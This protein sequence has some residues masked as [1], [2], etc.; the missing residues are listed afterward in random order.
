MAKAHFQ[1]IY[2]NIYIDLCESKMMLL[3]TSPPLFYTDGSRKKREFLDL[4]FQPMYFAFDLNLK[5]EF[6]VSFLPFYSAF[7]SFNIQFVSFSTVYSKFDLNESSLSFESLCY[8]SKY[9]CYLYPGFKVNQILDKTEDFEKLMSN[10]PVP[11]TKF[12]PKLFSGNKYLQSF[13]FHKRVHRYIFTPSR[14]IIEPYL[15]VHNNRAIN[16][17]EAD[18]VENFCLF[19]FLDEN[20][21]KVKPSEKKLVERLNQILQTGFFGP[22]KRKFRFLGATSSQVLEHSAWFTTYNPEEFLSSM[23][24][25]E[26]ILNPGLR[27]SRIG[28]LFSSTMSIC[29]IPSG[30]LFSASEDI[31][32]LDFKFKF[33]D[34]CGSI[35]LAVAQI[36]QDKLDLDFLPSAVQFRV[37]PYKG[38]LSVN[39]RQVEPFKFRPSMK[40]FFSFNRAFE[41]VGFSKPNKCYLNRQLIMILTS[42]GLEEKLFLD[43]LDNDI[44]DIFMSNINSIQQ[45]LSPDIPFF[46]KDCLD[47]LV[48]FNVENDNFWTNIIHLTRISMI[49]NLKDKARIHVPQGRLLL[50][51]IDEFNI[52]KENEVYI[53]ITL[54]D[55]S[56]KVIE[57]DLILI[58]NPCIHPGDLR[59]ATAI[60][61]HPDYHGLVDVII[62]P[63]K[64]VR[65]LASQTSGGDLDGDQ[66]TV[67]WDPKLRP[68][69]FFEPMTEGPT[70]TSK[71]KGSIIDAYIKI[72]TEDCIG[73]LSHAQLALADQR[74]G[75]FLNQDVIDFSGLISKAV[76]F[77][78]R[79]TS[80]D[81]PTAI[82][83]DLKYP[84]YLEKHSSIS[85]ISTHA[86]GFIYRKCKSYL[87][88]TKPKITP[89]I[90]SHDYQS[91]FE[92]AYN[93][94]SNKLFSIGR[95]YQ[96]ENEY[97]ILTGCVIL[98]AFRNKESRIRA[99]VNQMVSVLTKET[100]VRIMQIM[101]NELDSSSTNERGLLLKKLT[102]AL[103]C[104]QLQS[105]GWCVYEIL[106]EHDATKIVTGSSINTDRGL[107]VELKK[108]FDVAKKDILSEYQNRIHLMNRVDLV[109]RSIHPEYKAFLYGS[110]SYLL[111]DYFSDTDIGIYSNEPILEAMYVLLKAEFQSIQYIKNARV[112]IL[113]ST[114][115]SFDI[116][117][118]IKGICKTLIILH[119]ID[120]NP[121]F[122]AHFLL[123]AQFGRSFGLIQSQRL[124]ELS[125]IISTFGL[126]YLYIQHIRQ[127]NE[128]HIMSDATVM[129]N[130]ESDI[131]TYIEKL[132]K[133]LDNIIEK[134]ENLKFESS[135]VL[136]SF[137]QKYSKA[138]AIKVDDPVNFG[139]SLVNI[140]DEKIIYFNSACLEFLD[141]LHIYKNNI[142]KL[143]EKKDIKSIIRLPNH[144]KHEFETKL[145]F[146]KE[147][148]IQQAS[149]LAKRKILVDLTIDVKTYNSFVHLSGP[150]EDIGIVQPILNS[151][152]QDIVHYK[153]GSGG[154]TYLLGSFHLMVEDSSHDFTVV[155]FE[156]L[157]RNKSI[158]DE[159]YFIKS[160]Q[161]RLDNNLMK[162]RI[163]CKDQL[164]H[165]DC[166]ESLSRFKAT[167]KFGNLYFK[168]I[169]NAAMEIHELEDLL[170]HSLNQTSMDK[171]DDKK[172]EDDQNQNFRSL[173]ILDFDNSSNAVKEQRKKFH[174]KK[175]RSFGNKKAK[176]SIA[177]SR[178]IVISETLCNFLVSQFQLEHYSTIQELVI[179]S[180]IDGQLCKIV[181][182]VSYAP[183]FSKILKHSKRLLDA[184]LVTNDSLLKVPDIRYNIESKDFIKDIKEEY[185][186]ILNINQAIKSI[187]NI[188]FI[189]RDEVNAT[190][191][192]KLDSEVLK[193]FNASHIRYI[194][195]KGFSCSMN[196]DG[197]FNLISLEYFKRFYIN[198]VCNAEVRNGEAKVISDSV[199]IQ[200]DV[201]M[202]KSTKKDSEMERFAES[203]YNL[204]TDVI[205]VMRENVL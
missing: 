137:F 108:Y 70:I 82:V 164:L 74:P 198:K 168:N 88:L 195:R 145:S 109:C 15:L 107:N 36:V 143:F 27:L 98:K 40:K 120:T 112:P 34:G 159:L 141:L 132:P 113:K 43:Y 189:E 25:F 48:T 149:K 205:K 131:L 93:E 79:L 14:M 51:I 11:F 104:F 173:K 202:P 31:F 196:P 156:K 84:D 95:L 129:K 171:I 61:K 138:K 181:I 44:K 67:I 92:D 179:S 134:L 80:F 194:V 124:N 17:E 30:S 65:D 57:G 71:F 200:I 68:P 155:Q 191:P 12:E 174:M 117:Q 97:E 157:E 24:N 28:L 23:G 114:T 148:I 18:V 20:F 203:F 72:V 63:S 49:K 91:V 165:L 89:Q 58:K 162:F 176:P 7:G 125:Q 169:E 83:D 161:E 59:P 160:Q 142:S 130:Y 151:L 90:M 99:H 136:I 55:Q 150:S 126:I 153:R 87:N 158:R 183:K 39:N 78:K 69:E 3:F 38:V 21:N 86:L 106:F 172:V 96:C 119:V 180:K 133:N 111:F 9:S 32:T 81:F 199:E 178:A 128:F 105:F 66:F 110:S 186:S 62:M 13:K 192:F 147:N 135:Y 100:R 139:Q 118:N 170:V 103:K 182:D 193:M 52:L 2:P 47:R 175:V 22:Y 50:G 123:I 184:N 35:N 166:A 188:K 4:N 42:L 60:G 56:I 190:F 26:E 45:I 5:D 73:T 167:V 37:G 102:K 77:P 144:I 101:R 185:R 8:I 121:E 16:F 41:I 29:K 154:A 201:N 54:E 146:Y 85:Y 19:Q 1:T 10:L 46:S 33:S 187:G 75:H 152:I 6:L 122:Y 53:A 204:G 177:F 127:F 115:P 140:A 64:G 116:S 94:Y 163:A 76:D 197:A